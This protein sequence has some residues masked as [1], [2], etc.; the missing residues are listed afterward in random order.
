MIN[1]SS[2]SDI[3]NI[4]TSGLQAAQAGLGAVSNNVANVNTPG[5]AREVA[6]QSTFAAGG[7]ADGVHV[8][9]L[10]RV[11][12][13][14]LEAANF[15]AQSDNGSASILNSML[16]QAQSLF[17]D[18]SNATGDPTSGSSFFG[19]L[20]SVFS[21]FST[22][23]NNP[24]S[25]GQSAAVNQIESFLSQGQSIVSSL[26]T[27]TGQADQNIEADVSTANSLLQQI[28][29]LNTQISQATTTGGD[30]TGAQNQQ[31][32]LINQ[33]SN[34]MNVNVS[35]NS[36]GGV[37]IS[38][39]DGTPLVTNQSAATFSYSV[40]PNSGQLMVTP[41]GGVQQPMGSRLSSG[42]L[43][44]LLD[45]RNTQLPAIASQTSNLMSATANQLNAVSNSFSAQPA[46]TTL[47][48]RNTGMDLATDISGF[49]GTTNV[50]VL[51]SSGNVQTQ[52]A[53]D[54]DA[55]T[56]SVNGAA[57]VA[58]TPASFLTTL[59][60]Q[61]GASGSASFSNGALSIS[62]NGGGGVVVS[63]DPTTP[64][65]KAGQGF[66]DFFGLNDLV[67]STSNTDYDTGLT[68]ASQSGFPPGQNITF[69]LTA[70]DGSLLK[71]VTVTTPP[72]GTMQDML[73]A[74]NDRASGV[75]LYG[76][77][78]LDSN[79]E[80]SF[81]PN[82]GSGV[83]LAVQGDSTAN[84]ATGMSMS[85]LFGIGDATRTAAENT[86]SVNPAIAANPNLLQSASVN[87][88]GGVGSAALSQTSNS[89]AAAFANANSVATNIDAAGGVA[90]Q[91]GTLSDYAS[92]IAQAI[93]TQA[94]NAASQAGTASS[95]MN[96]TQSRLSSTEGVNMDQ[97]LVSLTTYQQ[98]YSA[99][100]RLV[101]AT[102]DMFTTLLGMTG[103]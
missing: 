63:D 68:P 78:S 91:T 7:A 34:L 39:A 31:S 41:V 81:T 19:Q 99:S 3:L 4:A 47:T 21:S 53:I 27:M 59:N 77:F 54:F 15:Q 85:Q 14:F 25:A 101:Q 22:L 2:L 55:G 74:L 103:T 61:L 10:T 80:L 42:E 30:P 11:T 69:A 32:T 46:P 48:G 90:A 36:T 98:A 1:F 29:Q 52:V 18:P 43:S 49:T 87:L 93:S 64:S 88:A 51:D 5:Y 95:V 8:D 17:G 12:N 26:Q 33:L 57:A 62:A 92:T 35:A 13:A 20:D 102:Q 97:E 89:A 6:N 50:A 84:T 24:S 23:E 16:D 44:G 75:G 100:A 66:S 65:S 58:F 67:Q 79:G 28:G 96:E 40:G 37:S 71:N 60:G 70:P 72:G 38:A 94:N 45:L 83:S 76:S 56:M 82:G 86:Y 9:S 73:N